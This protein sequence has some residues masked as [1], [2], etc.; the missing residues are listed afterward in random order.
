MENRQAFDGVHEPVYQG[1]NFDR[2]II[3][4]RNVWGGKDRVVMLLLYLSKE[5]I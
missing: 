2:Q 1:C 4:V 3:I 5:E